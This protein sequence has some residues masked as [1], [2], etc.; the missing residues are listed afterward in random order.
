MNIDSLCSLVISVKTF[1]AH[2]Q[3]TAAVSQNWVLVKTYHCNQS[4]ELLYFVLFN[5][6]NQ[7]EL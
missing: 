5:L 4:F 7:E 1:F 6:T 3:E 2:W